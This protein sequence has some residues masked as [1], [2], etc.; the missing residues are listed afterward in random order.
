MGSLGE[1]ESDVVIGRCDDQDCGLF[2]SS[3]YPAMGW[4]VGRHDHAIGRGVLRG[5]P[6]YSSFRLLAMSN[7]VILISAIREGLVV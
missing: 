1:V 7:L 6:G 3:D 5:R 4:R 2:G